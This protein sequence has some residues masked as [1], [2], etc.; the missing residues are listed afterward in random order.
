MEHNRVKAVGD[1]GVQNAGLAQ[2]HPMLQ[3]GL[4]KNAFSNGFADS[5]MVINAD[6]DRVAGPGPVNGRVSVACFGNGADIDQG[7]ILPASLL[8]DG[9]KNVTRR[10]EVDLHSLFGIVIRSG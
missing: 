8:L 1:A 2:R 3:A 5:I 6:F 7:D 10:T 9:P 4:R